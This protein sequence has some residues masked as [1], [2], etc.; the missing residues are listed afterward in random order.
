MIIRQSRS[1]PHVWFAVHYSCVSTVILALGL[2]AAAQIQN[3]QF[4]GLLISA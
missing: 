3:G 4:T 2:A 1:S